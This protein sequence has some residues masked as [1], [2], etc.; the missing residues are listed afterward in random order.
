ME[1]ENKTLLPTIVLKDEKKPSIARRIMPFALVLALISLGF[2]VSYNTT[3]KSKSTVVTPDTTLLKEVKEV[4]SSDTIFIKTA[5]TFNPTPNN[6]HPTHKPT[7]EKRMLKQ[8]THKPTHN[9]G[10]THKPTSDKPTKPTH[11]PTKGNPTYTSQPTTKGFFVETYN[12]TPVDLHPT[13]KPSEEKRML[14]QS[15]HKP[16]HNKGPTHKPTSTKPTKPTHK[17]T[18][19]NP[20]YTSQPTTKGF[21]DDETY[22]PTPVDLHPTKKPT[23]DLVLK[24]QIHN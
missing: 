6:L 4:R 1:A 16:T 13:K 21:V 5:Y 19:G 10:P 2:L 8:S 14:K 15:T 7:E 24:K 12:P 18:K 9:K 20:T 17:P 23:D 22:N 3:S 11:K